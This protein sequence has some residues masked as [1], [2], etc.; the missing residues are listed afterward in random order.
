MFIKN[1]SFHRRLRF[2]LLAIIMLINVSSLLMPFNSFAEAPGWQWAY[3]A[4]ATGSDYGCDI[5]LDSQGNVYVSG[6]FNESVT[7]GDITLNSAGSSDIFIVKYSSTGSVIWAKSFGGFSLDDCESLYVDAADNFFLTGFFRSENISFD[8]FSLYNPNSAFG[9]NQYYLIKC[10]ASGNVLWANTS[11]GLGNMDG[12]A[13]TMDKS[14]N[15]IVTG[16]FDGSDITFGSITL[17]NAGILSS[18]IFIVKYNAAG[19]ALWAK[20]AG[21]SGY[22]S[23]SEVVTDDSENLYFTGYF[24]S[25]T[26]NFGAISL[27]NA[28]GRDIFIA[29]YDAS[30][31]PVWAKSAAGSGDEIGVAMGIDAGN[32]L[33]LTG[34]SS[35]ESISFGSIVLTGSDY[36]K[37][38]TAKYD[39]DGNVIW[40]K[41]FSGDNNDEVIDL[42]IDN[43]GNTF[44][45]G[46]FGSSS[47]LFGSTELVNTSFDYSDLYIT[48][49]DP[50]GNVLWAESA[51]GNDDDE[52][53]AAAIDNDGNAYIPGSFYSSA[54]AFGTTTLTNTD[55]TENSSDLF[56]AKLGNSSG[57]DEQ[58][59]LKSL[60]VFPNPASGI[61]Q[62][63]G[64][65]NAFIELFDVNGRLITSREAA[66][67][68]PQL[69]VSTL[70]PGIYIVKTI[71]QNS[72]SFTRFIKE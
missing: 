12:N 43:Q 23:C 27:S 50:D 46:E 52:A 62:I 40:A 71:K 42:T 18:D 57:V 10:D 33:Y 41:V 14:G 64:A 15:I 68:T 63:R 31:N 5:K 21:G 29:K 35:S 9:Y 1:K 19:E 61:I 56:V 48:K 51:G 24:A 4:G 6:T 30:G 20:T 36:D 72:T 28:G 60:T 8:G 16:M 65:E 53:S 45:A 13:V 7:F 54:I 59:S 34:S 47:I 49:I 70:L 26:I 58:T 25:S 69:D 17:P 55:N 2:N 38:V 32:H 11:D 44:I 39:A 66:P 67:T 37:I 3:S 22:E